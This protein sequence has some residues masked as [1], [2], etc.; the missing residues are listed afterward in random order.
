MSQPTYS[1][2]QAG[3]IMIIIMP[4]LSLFMALSYYYQWGDEPLTETSAI[5]FVSVFLVIMLVFYNLTISIHKNVVQAKFGIGLIKFNLIVDQLHSAEVVT[6][7]WWYGWG[8]RFT[9][10]G[11]MYNIWGRKAVKMTFTTNGKKKKTVLLG[12]DE[13][14]MLLEQIKKL[15]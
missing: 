7:P 13:P 5:I 6:F 9:P 11:M 10:Q 4:I 15:K 8:I 1:K 2:S 14:E 3:W 12:T